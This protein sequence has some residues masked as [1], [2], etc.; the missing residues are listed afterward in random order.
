MAHES[1]R[2]PEIRG[3]TSRGVLIL[4]APCNAFVDFVNMRFTSGYWSKYHVQE[5]GTELRW[6][7]ERHMHKAPGDTNVTS[8]T[9]SSMIEPGG[10][11]ATLTLPFRSC[12]IK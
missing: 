2:C 1:F 10:T 5:V 6:C 9:T 12:T 3:F 11:D 8:A 4:V 7:N